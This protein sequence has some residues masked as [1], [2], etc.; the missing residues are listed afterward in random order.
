[1]HKD[2]GIQPAEDKQ[3]KKVKENDMANE[4]IT[5]EKQAIEMSKKASDWI[6]GDIKKG[7]ITAFQGYNVGSETYSALMKIINI[8]DRN[9][10]YALEVC[11]KDSIYSS[12]RDMVIQ[13][14]SV[15]KNQAYFIV[16]GSTLQLQRSYF[17]TQTV[18]K[19]ICPKFMPTANVAYVGDEIEYLH[20]DLYDYDYVKV[21]KS[22][23]E[24]RDNAIRCAYGSIVDTEKERKVY[25]CVM[26]WKEI[27]ACWAH[28]KSANVQNE[29]PQ[30]MAKRT[31]LNRMLKNYINSSDSIDQSLVDAFNRT[32]SNEF[33]ESEPQDP[34][35][36]QLIRGKSKGAEG[37]NVILKQAETSSEESSVNAKGSKK[38]VEEFETEDGEIIQVEKKDEPQPVFEEEFNFESP[39]EVEPVNV[40]SEE[41]DRIPW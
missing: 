1:M 39:K 35:V 7:A 9:G 38:A 22:S 18:F 40:D 14:L 24:N 13:G 31:L 29:F 34:V 20:D 21:I 12:L 36:G 41:Y 25:G 23:I 28:G 26:S 10:R 5:K 32:T 30:E 11:T 33:E 6:I 4:L 16:Y 8:R 15:T 2:N 19:R 27:K 37:L 17:G 3:T